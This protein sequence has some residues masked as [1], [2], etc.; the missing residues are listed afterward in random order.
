MQTPQHQ[1]AGKQTSEV[2]TEAWGGSICRFKGT[3]RGVTKRP[4]GA[5]TTGE[6]RKNKPFRH[7]TSRQ[8][9]TTSLCRSLTEAAFARPASST[10]TQETTCLFR[11]WTPTNALLNLLRNFPPFP[12]LTNH[13]Y[14]L[15]EQNTVTHFPPHLWG[16]A[17]CSSSTRRKVRHASACGGG[18][19]PSAASFLLLRRG[20]FVVEAFRGIGDLRL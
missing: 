14:A 18:G 10:N 4:E 2:R 1:S 20:G 13:R 17:T 3:K 16:F 12:P 6:L 19:R 15:A 8:S 9:A 5:E 11:E 7:V